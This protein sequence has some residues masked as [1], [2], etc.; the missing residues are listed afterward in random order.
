MEI[1]LS[2]QETLKLI[3]VESVQ[4][5]FLLQ[6]FEWCAVLYIIETQKDRDLGQILYDYNTE[7]MEL[8]FTEWFNSNEGA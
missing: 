6:I 1:V 8:T 3:L 5:V 7:N 4:S 2:I